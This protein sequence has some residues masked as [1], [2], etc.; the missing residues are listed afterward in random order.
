MQYY[1]KPSDIEIDELLKDLRQLFSIVDYCVCISVV[2][3]EPFIYP[4][5]EILLDYLINNEKVGSIEFTTN[6]TRIPSKNVL[7]RLRNDK[8]FVEISDYGEIDSMAAFIKAMDEYDVKIHMSTN[9]KWIDYGDCTARNREKDILKALYVSCVSGKLCKSLFKGKL[10]PCARAAH[11]S[12]LGY[13]DDIEFLDIYQCNKRDIITFWL[14]EYTM[15]CDYCDFTIK[16]K[17]FVEPAVQMNGKHFER[18]RCTLIF[19]DDYEEIWRANEWYKQQ[20]DNYKKRV[21]ELERWTNELQEAKDWLEEQYK[22]LT[23]GK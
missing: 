7:E 6:A 9:M 10:F 23:E 17:R 3:G 22:F 5:L 20:L 14:S 12:D 8:V 21:L 2:G 19:R 4:Y 11:L 18:S 13:A 16:K 15:A 1:E